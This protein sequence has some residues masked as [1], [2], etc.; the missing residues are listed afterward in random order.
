MF[1][2]KNPDKLDVGIFYKYIFY[3][4]KTTTDGK[5][6]NAEF[7]AISCMQTGAPKDCRGLTYRR[8]DANISDVVYGM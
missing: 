4:K 7:A 2:I 5:M 3:N 1:F 8:S 6:K